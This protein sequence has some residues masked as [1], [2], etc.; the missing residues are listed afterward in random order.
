MHS[1]C[2]R[3]TGISKSIKILL[4]ILLIYEEWYL[5]K[6]SA[7]PY[8]L[9][10]LAVLI[11]G[12]TFL[13]SYGSLSYYISNK[14]FLAWLFFGVFAALNALLFSA[15]PSYAFNSLGTYFS[16][17]AI[18]FCA[19]VVSQKTCDLEWLRR[20]MI[21]V[22]CMCAFSA[23]FYGQPY[24][25]G[26]YYVTT[27]SQNNNPNN[28]GL[29]MSIGI[30]FM[31]MPR[32]KQSAFAWIVRTLL[33]ASFVYVVVNTGSRSSLLCCVTVVAF[34]LYSHMKNTSGN[35]VNRYIK[36]AALILACM[37][38]LLVIVNTV[39]SFSGSG[40][41]L[42]RLIER[43]NSDSFGGRTELYD[44]AWEI[45]LQHP[46]VGIGYNCFRVLGGYGYFTHSTYME[47]LAC[48]GIVGFIL[49][50][51]PVLSGLKYAIYSMPE[52]RGSKIIL[53]AMLL[54]SGFFGIVFYNI[55]FMMVLYLII[56]CKFEIELEDDR[57]EEN[58][59]R[60]CN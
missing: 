52:N 11:V 7:I 20:A 16:F 45:F 40:T 28:L 3:E 24:K 32:K 21:I 59:E 49:F 12:F 41:A 57:L 25:N 48:T 60:F 47:L 53:L 17:L 23:I 1:K 58:I 50:L 8:V 39:A 19:G 14:S 55:V 46:I 43:F 37:S 9:Q 22:S 54:L 18:S 36:R 13:Y 26:L 29:M 33:S 51:G 10:I 2:Y 4:T 27:M 31:L 44:A 34:S 35:A 56:F 5:E 6:Y 38:A 15:E 42:N 30:F